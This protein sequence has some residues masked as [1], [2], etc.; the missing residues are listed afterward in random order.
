MS[1]SLLPSLRG[2]A[3]VRTLSADAGGDGVTRGTAATVRGGHGSLAGHAARR[4]TV[5]C[6][7]PK[8]GR[9]TTQ[10]MWVFSS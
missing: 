1:S 8:Y 9:P 5:C 3:A 2:I 6:K 4:L 10:A 7:Y